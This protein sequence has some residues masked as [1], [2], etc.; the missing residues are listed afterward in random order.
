MPT[1]EAF[2]QRMYPVVVNLID[3]GF[4]LTVYCPLSKPARS[5]SNLVARKLMSCG[6]PCILDLFFLFSKINFIEV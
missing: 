1:W 2:S 5:L 4:P 6:L 3:F